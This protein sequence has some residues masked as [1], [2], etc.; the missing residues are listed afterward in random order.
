MA[1]L[2]LKLRDREISRTAI[3]HTRTVI[4]REA[5]CDLVIDNAGISRNHAVLIFEEGEFRI[6]DTESQ[7]GLTV[8]GKRVG[9][10]TLN[11][12][13]V[14]G[15]GKFEL[16]LLDS[17]DEIEM[18]PGTAVKS[19]KPRNVMATMQMDS[20]AAA[21]MRDE[22]LAA[23]KKAARPER[24]R[25]ADSAAAPKRAPSPARPKPKPEGQERR[26]AA[27]RPAPDDAADPVE[28][29]VPAWKRPAAIAVAVLVPVAI[30]ALWLM[31]R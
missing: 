26:Q 12:G 3:R 15:I 11:Y 24:A 23:K 31:Q 1:E 13:D 18:R 25:P 16:H 27:R 29:P 28:L 19:D 17:P 9:D 30:A 5:S 20:A 4:G 10:A 14:I 7:N 8:N 21:R 2:L 6:R 22:I